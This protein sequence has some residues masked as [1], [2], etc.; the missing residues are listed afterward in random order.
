MHRHYYVDADENSTPQPKGNT[1]E[2]HNPNARRSH[3]DATHLSLPRPK[4]KR[5]HIEGEE[6]EIEKIASRRRTRWGYIYNVEWARLWIHSSRFE[7]V[8]ELVQDF[9]AKY[10]VREIMNV[11]PPRGNRR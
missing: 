9:N 2:V 11:K 3:A 4:S 6:W 10:L 8:Q 7:D 1:P 5:A